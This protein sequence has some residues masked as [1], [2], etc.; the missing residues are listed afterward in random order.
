MGRSIA[1]AVAAAPLYRD[2]APDEIAELAAGLELRRFASGEALMVQGAASDGAYV[3]VSGAVSVTAR[4]PGGGETAIA[5]LGPGDLVGEM[6]LLMKGGRRTAT[7]RAKGEVESL[8][9]DRRYFEAA[10]HLLRP[11][12]LKVL[13]R[14]GL[15]IA[16]RLRAVRRRGRALVETAAREG[17]LRP[18][19]D[20]EAGA[21]ATFD[22]RAFLPVLPCLRDFAADEIALLFTAARV[23]QVSRGATLAEEGGVIAA[24]RL[25]VRGA[26]M[27][28][29]RH[30]ERVHQLDI[31]GPGRFA[32][33][34]PV[35]EGSPAASALI[36]AEASTLLV[37]DA[38]QFVGLWNGEDRMSLRLLEAVNADLVLSLNT[39]SNHL[40][41]LTAQARVRD[42]AG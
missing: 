5:E 40:T 39:A 7:A 3:I 17:Q 13:R 18:P 4:L 24:P 38:A 10:L 9:T 14:L 32:G 34:A 8:F 23:E 19:P 15:T 27:M 11:T 42:L 31:L 41:R 21:T 33:V 2:L 26:L 20:G 37:F 22:V 30:G 1:D 6:A 12:S 35:L 28:G 25:V 29:Q 16:E 36:A